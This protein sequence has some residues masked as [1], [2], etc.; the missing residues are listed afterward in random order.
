MSRRWRRGLIW[1]LASTSPLSGCGP[2]RDDVLMARFQSQRRVFEELEAAGCK[3]P[4]WQ[5]IRRQGP[6]DP[7]MDQERESWFLS[8]MSVVGVNDL[9]IQGAEP[10]CSIQMGVWSEGFAG[11]PASYK[12]FRYDADLPPEGTV[13]QDTDARRPSNQIVVLERPLNGGWWIEYVDYP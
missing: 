9:I 6:T 10:H 8:R 3:L 7:A 13:V 5:D 12:N 1:L 4:L 2:P 11:T